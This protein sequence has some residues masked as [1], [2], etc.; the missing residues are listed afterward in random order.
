MNWSRV[1]RIPS[2]STV[3]VNSEPSGMSSNLVIL[4]C[5][6]VQV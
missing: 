6:S 1:L 3:I 2:T 5:S 4:Y